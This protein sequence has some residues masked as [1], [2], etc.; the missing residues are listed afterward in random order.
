MRSTIIRLTVT[1]LTFLIGL[2]I[3]PAPAGL[4]DHNLVVSP[5]RP[6]A[7]LQLSV[8]PILSECRHCFH[9]VAILNR[10]EMWAVGLD[11]HDSQIMWHSA[12]GGKTWERR[13]APNAGWTLSSINFVDQQHGWAAG[14]GNVLIRTSDG[15][16][17]WEHIAL[18]VFMGKNQA[19]FVDP[20]TGYIAGS[21][22][23]WDPASGRMIFGIRILRTDD[24][25]RTW[26]TCY[27]DDESGSVFN[28][29]ALSE[30]VVIL[31]IDG[32]K[33]LRTED[34]GKRWKVVRS[35]RGR[36]NAV[37]F[38]PDGT[39]W[40]VGSQGAF[41]QSLDEGQ[42]WQAPTGLP[43]A[44][45]RHDWWAI[46]FAEDGTGMAVSEDCAIAIT[47]DGG[48]SWSEIK[49]NLHEGEVIRANSFNEALRKIHLQAGT[50]VIFGSQRVY[51]VNAFR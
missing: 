18:P 11:S 49:T 44:L 47:Y 39:G 8:E 12:D 41:Y 3:T 13:I 9:D 42:T 35:D 31:A 5:A 15:G 2:L 17:S 51:R 22:G 32:G 21:T 45:L 33:L 23:V 7:P 24:G 43:S 28:I 34:G 1:L 26:H 27:Q 38:S 30:K 6:A 16:K 25:G 46:D 36:V 4:H 50:G 29:A 48:K 10:S 20:K 37:A 19:H 40:M 14:S